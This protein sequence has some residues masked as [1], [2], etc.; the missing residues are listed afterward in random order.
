MSENEKLDDQLR[1]GTDYV[2]LPQHLFATDRAPTWIRM[3]SNYHQYTFILFIFLLAQQAST[4]D[5]ESKTPREIR[6]R[7]STTI[8]QI[9]CDHYTNQQQIDAQNRLQQL[10]IIRPKENLDLFNVKLRHLQH[11]RHARPILPQYRDDYVNT[12]YDQTGSFVNERAGLYHTESYEPS[13]LVQAVPELTN[14]TE[15]SPLT[16]EETS[17]KLFQTRALGD[18]QTM[19]V[20]FIIIIIFLL[21]KRTYK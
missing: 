2:N 7:P 9:R 14:Q 17:S 21:H 6:Y 16:T 13:A 3:L 18:Y 19:R 11:P 15:D 5:F 10:E 1:N 8:S 4:I 12:L 20:S